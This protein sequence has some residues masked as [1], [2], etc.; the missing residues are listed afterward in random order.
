[1][2]YKTAAEIV[3]EVAP[4]LHVGPDT[5]MPHI[6]VHATAGE[7]GSARISPPFSIMLPPAS[8]DAEAERATLIE[9]IGMAKK[10]FNV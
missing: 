2:D 1:M 5:E 3:A 4:E 9:A 10:H 7:P 8:D 6:N